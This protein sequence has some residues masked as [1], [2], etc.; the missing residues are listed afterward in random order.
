MTKYKILHLPS[1]T[2]ISNNII[3]IVGSIKGS[4]S[5]RWYSDYEISQKKKSGQDVAGYYIDIFDSS[6]CLQDMLAAI[7]KEA[8]HY[9]FAFSD[10]VDKYTP[11]EDEFLLVEIPD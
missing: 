7:F 6:T 1:G 5:C 8:S 4:L 2:Y 11:S 10:E 3:P 9:Y